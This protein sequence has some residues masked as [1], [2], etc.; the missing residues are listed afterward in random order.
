VNAY[1]NPTNNE[2]VFPAGILQ[3]PFFNAHADDAV[4]YGAIGVVIGHEMTHG[5]D[6]QGRKYDKDG[7][8]N[9]WWTPEDAER[10]TEKTKMLGEQFDHFTLLDSLHINGAMTMGENIADLG[11]LNIAYDAYQLSL[12]GKQ[13]EKIDGFTGDQRFYMGYAQVWR[14]NIRD[15]ELMR[16]LKVDVHSPAEARVNVP[17]FNLDKF[18]EA[19]NISDS[20]KL[21][22]PEDQRAHIW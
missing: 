8:M 19:F 20:D 4:N 13:P 7:N 21:Y 9:D 6:D 5:F 16:R 11:G 22:I 1:Y 18:I 14:A 15:K 3:P 17:L 10:F 2:I 12:N